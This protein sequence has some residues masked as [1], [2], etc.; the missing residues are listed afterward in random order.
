LYGA[1]FQHK[2]RKWI[3][4]HRYE[5]KEYHTKRLK[6]KKSTCRIVRL[7]HKTEQKISTI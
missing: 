1:T 4:K 6:H 7:K 3:H 2:V 5:N